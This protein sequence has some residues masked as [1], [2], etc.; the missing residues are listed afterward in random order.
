[1][2]IEQ[3][4]LMSSKVLA[5]V[6]GDQ[7]VI[8]VLE[9]DDI[10]HAVPLARALV[11]GRLKAL[12]VTFRTPATLGAVREIVQLVPEARVGVGTVLEPEQ[13]RQAKK[14]GALFA[15]SPGSTQRLLEAAAEFEL[16]WLPGVETISAAMTLQ[17][18][19]FD[20]LKRFPADLAWLKAIYG[21]LPN[22]RF[23]PTGGLNQAR[24][25]RWLN[26]PN[27]WCVGGSW[28]AP[29]KLIQQEAWGEIETLARKAASLKKNNTAPS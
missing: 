4:G 24:A 1:M 16:P 25:Q 6:I 7:P 11:A 3:L 23:C 5:E 17:E 13:F 18:L 21:P 14:A 28:V 15:V 27:V 10:I 8:P 29:T 12:E 9:I 20:R 19:G 26:L 2:R 22:L